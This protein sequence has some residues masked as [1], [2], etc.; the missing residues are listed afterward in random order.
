QAR[1]GIL[2]A[3]PLDHWLRRA[4][5]S[6]LGLTQSDLGLLADCMVAMETVAT[7]LDEPTGYFVNHWKL[8]ERIAEADKVLDQR[9]AAATAARA[10]QEAAADEAVSEEAIPEEEPEVSDDAGDFDPEVAAIFTEEATEL[11]EASEHALSDW[12]SEPASAEYRSGL[13]RPLHTLKGG[14]RMAGITAMGDLSHELETLVMQVDNGSVAPN[15]ALFDVVQASLD[16]LARMREL[17]ANGRRVSPARA[18][19]ARI[20]SLTRPKSA[21]PAAAKPAAQASRPVAPAGVAAQTSA[22]GQAGSSPFFSE[23]IA[24][25]GSA[26]LDIDLS[27]LGADAEPAQPA[28]Q[29]DSGAAG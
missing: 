24:E 7:H 22:P 2:V 14:A 19:I 15:D 4:F 27:Q 5:S 10:A 11:I 17:V 20:P 9:I 21:Q 26:D 28:A 6:G 23:Q 12:R 16:E 25:I 13:K 1:H 18:M 29:S 3:E 8:Q